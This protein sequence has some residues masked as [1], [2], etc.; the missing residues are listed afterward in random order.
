MFQEWPQ[1]S[2]TPFWG[3]LAPACHEALV[4]VLFYLLGPHCSQIIHPELRLPLEW[5]YPYHGPVLRPEVGVRHLGRFRV[6]GGNQQVP[7]AYDVQAPCKTL[8][9]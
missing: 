2:G 3:L 5:A 6:E 7:R 1:Q 4:C 8:H 9:P